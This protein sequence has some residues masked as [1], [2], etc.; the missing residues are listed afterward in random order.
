MNVAAEDSQALRDRGYWV[1]RPHFSVINL[2]YKKWF[3]LFDTQCVHIVLVNATGYNIYVCYFAAIQRLCTCTT[4]V[5]I[6]S[7]ICCTTPS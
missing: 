4:P 6:M 2:G 1:T 7:F 5:A 3:T